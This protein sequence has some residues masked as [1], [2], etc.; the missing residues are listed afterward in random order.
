MSQKTAAQIPAEFLVPRW[1]LLRTH[2]RI[3]IQFKTGDQQP[4]IVDEVFV[5][6]RILWIWP[7]G[8]KVRQLIHLAD[9]GHIRCS[10][11]DYNPARLAALLQS[12]P[13]RIRALSTK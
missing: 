5:K 2:D 7:P 3:L 6:G 9:I 12:C 8:P 11:A 10:S 13:S 1:E 4:G